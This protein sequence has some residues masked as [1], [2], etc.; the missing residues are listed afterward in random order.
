V[1]EPLPPVPRR[2][3]WLHFWN[4]FTL[5]FVTPLLPLGVSA[6]WIG[7][8][9][10]LADG[11]GQALRLVTGRASDRSGR[12]VPW[13]VAGYSAN[14]L[15]RPLAGIGM[16]LAWPWWI[17]LCRVGDRVGKGLRGSASDALLTDWV[18]PASRPWA[19]GLMRT[20]DHL[21]ATAGAL[22][23]AATAWWV[24]EHLGYDLGWAVL[25]LVV[26]MVAMLALCAGLRERPGA[27]AAGSA[28]AGWWP[29]HPG[30]RVPL[31]LIA[32]A[33]LGAKLGPLLILVQVS[34]WADGQDGWRAWQMCLAWAA[35]GLA[36]TL[37]AAG[38]AWGAQRLGAQRFLALGWALG[39]AVFAGLALAPSAWLAWFGLAWGVVAGL[40]EGAEKAWIADLAGPGERAT[41]F[42]ALGLVGAGAALIGSSACGLGLVWIGAPVFLLP[43]A[44]MAF[45]TI[46]V[47]L[48]PR[49]PAHA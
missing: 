46:G 22:T 30:V 44:A 34:G 1:P 11:L 37:V 33:S 15:M 40:T 4:D 9:E 45:G 5:D 48:H 18:E 2:L 25:A 7:V 27:V 49:S 32:V 42:G 28:P 23:A 12:R 26:P 43:A 3:A 31:G 8:M 41:T 35:L 47:S 36:Q 21:G 38:S 19:F 17:V 13:V 6:V 14:A 10:G 24:G 16:L 39:A 20:Y 29:Q